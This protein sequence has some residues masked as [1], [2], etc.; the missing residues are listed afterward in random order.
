MKDACQYKR[1]IVKVG[2]SAITTLNGSLDKKFM[3]NIAKSLL[4]LKSK[5]NAPCASHLMRA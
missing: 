5:T 1:V 2:T 3:K 4:T